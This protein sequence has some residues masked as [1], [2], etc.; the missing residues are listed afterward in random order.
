MFICEKNYS[1]C[2]Y[3]CADILDDLDDEAREC[4]HLIEVAPV[5]HAHWIEIPNA[6][7]CHYRCSSCEIG[8]RVP[9]NYCPDCGAKMDNNQDR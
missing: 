5:V 9:Y 3:Q 6:K 1:C 7:H 8:H 2:N 4:S